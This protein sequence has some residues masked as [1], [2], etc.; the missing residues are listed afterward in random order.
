MA[1]VLGF[2]DDFQHRGELLVD[3]KSG[4]E[5]F[6]RT[7]DNPRRRTDYTN[8]RKEVSKAKRLLVDVVCCMYATLSYTQGFHCGL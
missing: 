2:G 6:H 8:K 3:V 4:P 7:T 5:R 1:L